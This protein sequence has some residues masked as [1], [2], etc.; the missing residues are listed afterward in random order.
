M[1]AYWIVHPQDNN[2]LIYELNE[3]GKFIGK[4]PLTEGDILT[5]N[6]FTDLTI[7]LKNIFAEK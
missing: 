5:S 4:P 6:L 3:E 2:V 1:E 7:D